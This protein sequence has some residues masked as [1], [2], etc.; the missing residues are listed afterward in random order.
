VPGTAL[1]I[2]GDFF[3]AAGSRLISGRFPTATDE[4]RATVV[5]ESFARVCCNGA[6]PVGLVVLAGD[7]PFTI[8]GVVKDIYMR[9]F[10]ELPRPTVFVPIGT[11]G[12]PM[13]GVVNYVV[14][15][16]TRDGTLAVAAEREVRAA[17]SQ[18]TISDGNTMRARLM[19]S[20][21]DRSFATLLIVF[22][23]LA[24]VGVSAAGLVGVVGFVVARRT[25]EIAIR[26]AIGARVGDVRLL[27]LREAVTAAVFG[28][29]VG[30]AGATTLSKAVES[31]LYGITPAD[32]ISLATATVL[33]VVVVLGA[34]WLPAR[35]ATRV[36]PTVALRA[37]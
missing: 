20:V 3:E 25:R 7:H 15:T 11:P 30:F 14:R 26:I 29:A 28:A 27:V 13:F 36:S 5:S 22:F 4:G 37:E 9:A 17:T 12:T 19:K 34:A 2:T 23:A 24:A 10:D 32:P 18:V 31:W 16:E 6:T 35:R 21:N 33:M 1:Q 8:L